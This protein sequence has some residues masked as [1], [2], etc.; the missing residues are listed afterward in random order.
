MTVF[1][2]PVLQDLIHE[3]IKNNLDLRI[4]AARVDEARARAGIARS[5]KFPTIDLT[6][7]AV[8]NEVARACETVGFF[9]IVGHDVD[10]DAI[11][12]DVALDRRP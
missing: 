10:E 3:A 4:A 7:S 11:A 5:F 12:S 9:T 2:D 1:S 6:G 8:A